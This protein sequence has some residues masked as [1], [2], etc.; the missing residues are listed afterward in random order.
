MRSEGLDR[1][2]ESLQGTKEGGQQ[3]VDLVVFGLGDD[4]RR[5]I[6]LVELNVCWKEETIENTA[7]YRDGFAEG[8]WH[9]YRVSV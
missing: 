2:V 1:N 9:S 7:P 6:N 5:R 4:L 8:I 3:R